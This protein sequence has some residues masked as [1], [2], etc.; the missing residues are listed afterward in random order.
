LE[1]D[2][3]FSFCDGSSAILVSFVERV[4]AGRQ[5]QYIDICP[6]DNRPTPEL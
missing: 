3:R 4:A 6:N 2:G 1:T 5:H